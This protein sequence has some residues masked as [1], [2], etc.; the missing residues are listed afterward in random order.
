MRHLINRT[1]YLLVYI[2]ILTLLGIAI[3]E[4]IRQFLTINMMY[5]IAGICTIGILFFV[6]EFFLNKKEI[7]GVVLRMVGI[8]LCITVILILRAS[9][10]NYIST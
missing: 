10:I 1:K 4:Y 9:F 3:A 7:R 6:I 8:A 5:V 2:I